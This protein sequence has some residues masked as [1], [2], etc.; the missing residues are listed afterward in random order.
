[1]GFTQVIGVATSV[2]AELWV[3]MV[4]RC[5]QISIYWR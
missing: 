5:T 2:D 4:A 1:M 3:G